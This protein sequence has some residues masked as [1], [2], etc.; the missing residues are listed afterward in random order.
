MECKLSKEQEGS[1]SK[2]NLWHMAVYAVYVATG[3][4]GIA[5]VSFPPGHISVVWLP[6]GIAFLAILLLGPLATLPVFLGSLTIKL[7]YLYDDDRALLSLSVL[8]LVAA[9]ETLQGWIAHKF[10]NSHFQERGI[11]SG[12]DVLTFF[13]RVAFAS[14][15][16]T[17]WLIVLLFIAT[18]YLQNDLNVLQNWAE[19]TVVI[20]MA[21]TLGIFLVVALY[22]SYWLVKQDPWTLKEIKIGLATLACLLTVCAISFSYTELSLYLLLPI[23]LILIIHTGYAGSSIGL[24]LVSFWTIIATANGNGPFV[25]DD[26]YISM[27]HIMIFVLCMGLTMQFSALTLDNLNANKRHMA[28]TIQR[29]TE[30]LEKKNR[31]LLELASTDHLTGLCNRRSFEKIANK[32]LERAQRY[33]T[34]LSIL[35]LD[36]DFFKTI[37]DS[38]GHPFGDEVLKA[39]TDVCLDC[40]RKTDLMARLGGEEFVVLLPETTEYLATNVG[41]KLR[42]AISE[43]RLTTNEGID[44]SITCSIG[45]T[46]ATM[47][48][49]NIASLLHRADEAL[50]DAKK[51]GRNKVCTYKRLQEAGFD[52]P[53]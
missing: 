30:E 12:A 16:F 34:P 11:S 43:I 6:S 36:L 52:L 39:F 5:F 3:F 20:T 35:A 33:Q 40:L 49:D 31:Q 24:T 28:K 50:Y 51:F 2:P 25:A 41:E 10:W 46:T 17:V 26:N 1:I 22:Q 23:F 15:A 8:T 53:Q 45:V 47:Q 48:D 37:N 4:L 13:L 21:H 14:C 38:Y 32:E 27:I 18:G 19:N 9:I 7:P 44:V 29:R 42:L